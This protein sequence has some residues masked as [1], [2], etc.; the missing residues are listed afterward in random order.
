MKKRNDLVIIFMKKGLLFIHNFRL[1]LLIF[2]FVEFN[3]FLK[4]QQE[5]INLIF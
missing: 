1:I 3:F 5:N 2:A 4:Q